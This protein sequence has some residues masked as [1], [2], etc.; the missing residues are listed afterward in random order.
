[1]SH[2]S[3]LAFVTQSVRRVYTKNLNGKAY[4]S[5]ITRDLRCEVREWERNV[6]P[7]KVAELGKGARIP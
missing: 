7:A 5:Q 6:K 1:M 2:D 4:F 3:C